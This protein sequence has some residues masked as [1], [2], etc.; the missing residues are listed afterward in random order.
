[1]KKSSKN[2]LDQDVPSQLATE[3][4]ENIGASQSDKNKSQIIKEFGNYMD[5]YYLQM[6]I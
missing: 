5:N 3:L 2:W 4:L 1:M 6:L